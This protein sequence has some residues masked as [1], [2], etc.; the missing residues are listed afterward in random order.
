MAEAARIADQVG[1]DRLTLAA[2]AQ[3]LGVA[4]PSLY[5]HI[6]GLEA[7]QRQIA[8]R[9][10]TELTDRLTEAALGRSGRDALCSLAHA[11]RAY[12]RKHPGS[13]AA[14]LRAPDA[15]DAAHV[16]AGER[17]VRV[18]YAILA[19]YG[20]SDNQLV[21]ATRG[22]RSALHGFVSLE[23]AGGF[24][25][26]QDIDRSYDRLID[27]LDQAYASWPPERQIG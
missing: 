2:V 25:L 3:Q 15:A 27:V 11:Y 8:V 14:T 18:V 23:M 6:R 26:P 7:L 16:A 21:D 24:G 5:K 10:L 1:L 22:L 12:A 19:G 17:S 9:A 20:L 13:Y 4:L